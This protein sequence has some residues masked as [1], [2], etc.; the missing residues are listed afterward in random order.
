MAL[1][2]EVFTFRD[3]YCPID[4]IATVRHRAMAIA[5]SVS[6]RVIAEQKTAAWVYGL[7]DSPPTP[8]EVCTDIDV[9]TKTSPRSGV[10]VREVVIDEH[11]LVQLGGLRLTAPLRTAID[12]A[13]FQRDFGPHERGLIL[14]LARLG[15]FDLAACVKVIDS[16]RNLPNKRR[17]LERLAAA[18]A[19]V[20]TQ[21]ALTR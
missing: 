11:E 21:P 16:R 14:G 7:C 13:R 17:A 10:L 20:G 3:V 6:P 19:A 4:E 8:L 18:F 9:R 1:D 12:L 5:V 15:R 2:G